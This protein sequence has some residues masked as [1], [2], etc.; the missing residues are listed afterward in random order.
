[1]NNCGVRAD[2]G[3][4]LLDELA[5]GWA[6]K[7]DLETLLITSTDRCIIGQLFGDWGTG[8]DGLTKLSGIEFYWGS[9][10]EIS[11]LNQ[12][13]YGFELTH[14]EYMSENAYVHTGQELEGAW[15]KEIEA[16]QS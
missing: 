11:R 13:E 7:V 14:E 9:G 3:A 5:P 16:R 4:K 15:I 10:A 6:D 1:M 2:K 12:E 8:M